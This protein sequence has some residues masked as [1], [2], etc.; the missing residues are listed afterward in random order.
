MVCGGI[1]D[2][3]KLEANPQDIIIAVDRGYSY[4]EKINIEP[5][6]VVGDFD[7]LGYTPQGVDV[8]SLNSEKDDS[9]TF[10]AIDKGASC[11][12]STIIMYSALG[13]RLSHLLYNINALEYIHSK[14]MTAILK[15]AGITAIV[16]STSLNG[17]SARYVSVYPLSQSANVTLSGFKYSGNFTMTKQDSLGLSNEP[18]ENA[19]VEVVEGKVL[20]ILEE[21]I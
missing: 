18:M 10:I 11:G 1:N 2:L 12:C 7:S 13:G 15:S 19:R 20:V 21:D 5:N 16:C 8:V 4:L 9:D 3:Q 17:L 6:I 14:G